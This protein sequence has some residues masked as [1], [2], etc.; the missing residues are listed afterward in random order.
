VDLANPTSFR[1]LGGGQGQ[2]A[3][4]QSNVG[5]FTG[6]AAKLTLRIPFGKGKRD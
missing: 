1:L 2:V 6:P 3:A 5:G 4:A